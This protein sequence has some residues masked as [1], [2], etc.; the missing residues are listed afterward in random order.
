MKGNMK[1]RTRIIAFLLSIA[2]IFTLVPVGT[3]AEGPAPS[4]T[5]PSPP[6]S[7]GS[8]ACGVSVYHNGAETSSLVLFENGSEILT[9]ET[10]GINVA[11]RSWQI[12]TPDGKDWVSIYGKNQA[13]LT[14]TYALV[15]SMLNESDFAYLRLRVSDGDSYYVSESVEIRVDH[16]FSSYIDTSSDAV[17]YA[18]AVHRSVKNLAAADSEEHKTY[19]IVINYIFDNGGIAYELGECNT[20]YSCTV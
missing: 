7:Q 10:R 3:V 17:S 20:V 14:V 4:D 18:S 9:S 15:A 19:S 1:L 8:P 2:A 12:L 5:A 16:G 6:A 11:G 13:S